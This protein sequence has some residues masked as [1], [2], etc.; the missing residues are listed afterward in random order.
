MS[1]NAVPGDDFIETTVAQHMKDNSN[2]SICSCCSHELTETSS[3]ESG[4]ISI[5][6]NLE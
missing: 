2:H 3:L 4:V 6:Q 5:A 1:I